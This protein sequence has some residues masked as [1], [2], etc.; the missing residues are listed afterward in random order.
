[1]T[2]SLI[3]W[4]L[5]D[6]GLDITPLDLSTKRNTDSWQTNSMPLLKVQLNLTKLGV[7]KK[8]FWTTLGQASTTTPSLEQ[9]RWGLPKITTRDWVGLIP[10]FKLWTFYR[11][12]PSCGI[13]VFRL[14]SK[15]IK[16]ILGPRRM[17]TSWFYR[18]LRLLQT[19]LE[20]TWYRLMCLTITLR[21][22]RMVRK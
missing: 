8:K 9:V 19:P 18:I 13:K 22:L 5:E 10:W 11:F 1:M 6:T 4:T 16:R 3:S 2:L 20:K 14:I 12:N 7:C 15:S 21:S 17:N